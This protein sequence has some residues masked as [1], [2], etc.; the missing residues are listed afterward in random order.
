MGL[1]TLQI[2]TNVSCTNRVT[3]VPCARIHTAA[4]SVSVRTDT[5]A[6]GISA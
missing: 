4:T 3:S 5:V 6:T 2:L 1:S